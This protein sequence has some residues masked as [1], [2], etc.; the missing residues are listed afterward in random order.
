MH[1]FRGRF[2]IRQPRGAVRQNTRWDP[3]T[4][5]QPEAGL[6]RQ[7]GEPVERV[8]IG[9]LG[10]YRL[11]RAEAKRRPAEPDGLGPQADQVHL[12]ALLRAHVIG[13]MGKRR[14]VDVGVQLAIHPLEEVQVEGGRDALTVVVCRPHDR[15]ILVDV[16][17]DQQP[18]SLAHEPGDL[19]EEPDGCRR[20]EVADRRAREINHAPR[21]DFADLGQLQSGG[22]IG[23]HRQHP[24]PGKPSGQVDGRTL[25][26]PVRH[27][28]RHVRPRRSKL[29]EQQSRLLRD[30]AA[31]LDQDA[32]RAECFRHFV[33]VRR[34]SLARPESG[35]TR[36]AR[37]SR[38][39]ARNLAHRKSIYM[40]SPFGAG[41]DQPPRP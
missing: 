18:S 24:Q 39:R 28:D 11:A 33:C 12:D 22:E 21:P 30:S 34:E 20:T 35:N 40:G 25:E 29:F 15:L 31:K 8:F 23:M 26:R 2:R 32:A 1:H 27:V 5:A 19:G 36:S 9:V 4:L 16:K 6:R 38:R 14:D 41:P 7:A 13:A 37:R 17:A 3:A 10:E